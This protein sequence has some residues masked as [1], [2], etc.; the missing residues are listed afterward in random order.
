MKI[1]RGSDKVIALTTVILLGCSFS[2]VTA[3]HEGSDD[4]LDWL[5]ES[6]PGE[7]GVDYPILAD[8]EPTSFSCRDRVF[9]GKS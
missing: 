2:C 6:I 1:Q 8:V 4:P 5:R 3:D 9:G 7:P